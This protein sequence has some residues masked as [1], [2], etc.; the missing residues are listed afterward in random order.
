[1]FKHF[2]YVRTLQSILKSRDELN[3]TGKQK[4]QLESIVKKIKE[5][6]RKK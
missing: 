4:S 1:M 3:L 6:T 2:V 5:G